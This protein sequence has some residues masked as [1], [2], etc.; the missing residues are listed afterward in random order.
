MIQWNGCLIK[1]MGGRG[2][3]ENM[4]EEKQLRGYK[5]NGSKEKRGGGKGK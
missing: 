2:G 5:I 1:K 3:V 4:T